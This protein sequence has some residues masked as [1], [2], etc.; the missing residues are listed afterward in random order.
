MKNSL[1]FSGLQFRTLALVAIVTLAAFSALGYPL[2]PPE[3]IAG[4][5]PALMIG[6]ISMVELKTAIDK[7]GET[8][9][10]FMAKNDER[11]KAIEAK[12][13]APA[14]LTDQVGKINTDLNK[15]SAEIAEILKKANRPGANA[16]EGK[17]ETPEQLAYKAGLSEYLRKGRDSGLRELESKANTT[18]S[19]P[20]GGYLVSKEM[21]TNI[22]RFAGV[23]CAMRRIAT[24][25]TVGKTAYKKLMKT[26]GISGGWVGETEAAS[27]STTSQWAEIE[28][29]PA[30]CYAEPRVYN[31]MLEDSDYDLEADI[32][33][34][35]G[36]TF[37]EL[38]GA[39][40]ISGTGVKSPR[41]ITS[42]TNVANAS[43]AHGKVGYVATGQSAAFASSNPSDSL[44]QLQHALKSQ[45][46]NGAVFLMPDTVL[47]TVRQMK[48][49]SGAF[50]LWQPDST[51][52]FGGRL[53]GSVV[54]IDDNMPVVAANS[55]SIAY[56]NFKRAYTIVDRR[57][58]AVI[59]DN[60][61]VK[62]TT[63]FH[64]SKRV[65]GGI[66]NFEAIKLL[67]FAAS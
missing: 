56:G 1:K 63:I 5:T 19:D 43:F 62:G 48:D 45:Y 10:Q 38:E 31:D 35:A 47:A 14:E 53:L 42:Y 40:F 61:T 51:A 11:I 27:E 18:G 36:I 22:D 44:I 46:R 66:T 67:K 8:W 24:V 60:V 49:A 3:V 54:E 65:G 58:I 21:D 13:Y 41:G 16:T 9:G 33:S 20:D 30:R 17:D 37:A 25:R 28:I 52:G 15:L 55:Y 12:G 59:R 64:F 6:E 26:R 39:G 4:M 23:E 2:A 7:Q 34:E 32:T 50:Y 57:G 29:V